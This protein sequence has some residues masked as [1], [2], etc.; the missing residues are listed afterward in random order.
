VLGENEALWRRESEP[1]TRKLTP[2]EIALLEERIRLAHVLHLRIDTLYFI[3]QRLLDSVVSAADTVLSPRRGRPRGAKD[4]GRHRKVRGVLK[5]RI[6][7][8]TA[9]PASSSLFAAIDEVRP[10]KDYRDDYVAHAGPPTFPD[11]SPTRRISVERHEVMTDRSG[12]AIGDVPDV[13]FRYVNAWLDYLE[14]VP[15]PFHWPPGP[16]DAAH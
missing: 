11:R 12:D 6:R 16:T 7:D 8:G 2:P 4:L 3:A 5:E 15:L 1:G 10:V 14:T 9:P 13:L